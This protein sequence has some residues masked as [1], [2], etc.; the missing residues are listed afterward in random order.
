M[1]DIWPFTVYLIRRLYRLILI[2][3]SWFAF[4]VALTVVAYQFKDGT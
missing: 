2:P 1:K 3:I 4:C